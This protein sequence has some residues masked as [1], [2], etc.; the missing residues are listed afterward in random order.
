[1]S[2]NIPD[3]MI[4]IKCHKEFCSL[5]WNFFLAVWRPF[6]L[7]MF[8]FTGLRHTLKFKVVKY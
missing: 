5:R 3:L 1:M 4:F 6:G 7:V 2:E 8:L